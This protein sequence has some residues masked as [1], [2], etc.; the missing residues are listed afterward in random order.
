MSD[1]FRHLDEPAERGYTILEGIIADAPV[2]GLSTD[3]RR[4]EAGLGRTPGNNRFEG[5]HTTRTYNLL[6][7]GGIWQQVPVQRQVL[8]LVEGVPGPQCPVSS[9]ASTAIAPGETAQVV[10]ADDQIPPLTQPWDLDPLA[11][12]L[13]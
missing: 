10:H 9:L 11:D 13:P 3:V 5:H 4:L 12:Q 7:H 1:P 6:A 2:D 8:G